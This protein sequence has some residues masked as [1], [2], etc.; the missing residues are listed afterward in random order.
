MNL[1]IDKEDEYLEVSS[2]GGIVQKKGDLLV[3]SKNIDE[4]VNVR[5]ILK[6]R[7]YDFWSGRGQ[8]IVIDI[9]MN[10]GGASL[11]FAKSNDVMKV[12]GFEPFPETFAQAE[13]NFELNPSIRERI[14]AYP[15]GISDTDEIRRIIYNKNMT[16]GQSTDAK[17]N[18]KARRNYKDWELI[19]KEDDMEVEVEV[20]DIK[21]ILLKIYQIHKQEDMILKID[22][23]GEEYRIIERI[24]ECTLFGRI[25]VIMMEWHYDGNERILEILRENQYMYCNFREGNN[26]LIYAFKES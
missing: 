26:G 5:D 23:E 2:D 10:V 16:C 17:A 21:N 4:F 7:C 14:E 22:C 24:N 11:Y 6:N 1:K 18:L 15:Y 19:S 13:G 3:K 20:K 8:K 25:K 12:Y 9:G